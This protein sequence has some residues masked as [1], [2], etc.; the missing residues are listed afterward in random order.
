M[1]FPG[2]LARDPACLA[3]LAAFQTRP[4]DGHSPLLS[5]YALNGYLGAGVRTDHEVDQ[6]SRGAG[7]AR[8]RA[9]RC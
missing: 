7:E 1:N 2:L 5:G 6:P 8:A 9:C 4:I 3:K